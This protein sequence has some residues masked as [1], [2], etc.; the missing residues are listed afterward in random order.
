M[1]INAIKFKFEMSRIRSGSG[2]CPGFVES[3]HFRGV[4]LSHTDTYGNGQLL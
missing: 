2:S 3:N 1:Y 4:K